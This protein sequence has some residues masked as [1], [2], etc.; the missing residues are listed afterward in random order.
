METNKEDFPVLWIHKHSLTLE[1][2]IQF[3]N[4]DDFDS[5]ASLEDD[6]SEEENEEDHPDFKENLDMASS[7]IINPKPQSK[8]VILYDERGFMERAVVSWCKEAKF[9]QTLIKWKAVD[10]DQMTGSEANYVVIICA[11]FFAYHITRARDK[12][13]LMPK[14]NPNFRSVNKR[15]MIKRLIAAKDAKR[16]VEKTVF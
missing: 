13:I 4:N 7:F 2:Q 9:R 12:L 10:K 15:T 14:I 5:D 1:Y 3:D 16:V 8:G 6:E 11:E